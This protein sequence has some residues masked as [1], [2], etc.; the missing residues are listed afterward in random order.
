MDRKNKKS[1][2]RQWM[3]SVDTAQSSSSSSKKLKGVTGSTTIT[4]TNNLPLDIIVDLLSR[5]PVKSLVRFQ[6]V[7]KL[8]NCL[9]F[10]PCFIDMHLL[11]QDTERPVYLMKA[12]NRLLKTHVQK[13]RPIYL[14]RQEKEE[15]VL[16]RMVQVYQPSEMDAAYFSIVDSCNGLVCLTNYYNSIC[17]YNPSTRDYIFL[18]KNTV[19]TLELAFAYDP[20]S[21]KYKVFRIFP[22]QDPPRGSL[23]VSAYE[24]FTLGSNSWRRKEQ[25]PYF[26]SETKHIKC[27]GAVHWL[28]GGDKK[29]PNSLLSIDISTEI[30][31]ILHP[32]PH[33]IDNTFNPFL[34]DLHGNLALCMMSKNAKTMEIWVLTQPT[35]T[36]VWV[37]NYNCRTP[38]WIA[39]AP[40]PMKISP[41]LVSSFDEVAGDHETPG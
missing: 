6:I 8:W 36:F 16:D 35:S 26:P 19:R 29:N 30:P 7:C 4:T 20:K 31:R 25:I 17:I 28:F 32:I 38:T 18:P 10:H 23:N 13:F 24:V 39:R 34:I 41:T 33:S 15:Q 9:I 1:S 37:Q 21:N 40:V 22:I 14:L 5:L 27:G 12:N 11:R 2:S 3:Q